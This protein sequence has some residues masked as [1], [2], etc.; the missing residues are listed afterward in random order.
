MLPIWAMASMTAR[1]ERRP[2]SSDC[3]KNG[4][5]QP[6]LLGTRSVSAPAG[7]STVFGL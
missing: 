5:S 4:S 3:G 7:V 1:D 6:R 2:R